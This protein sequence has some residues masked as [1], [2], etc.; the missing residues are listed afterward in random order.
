VQDKL[1]TT[2]EMTSGILGDRAVRQ[3]TNLS[4]TTIWRLE[5]HGKFP[6][7]LRLSG[8]RVGWRADEVLAWIQALPRGFAG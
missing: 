2:K 6:R 7:R 1:S 5:R 4:R 8:N 3:L